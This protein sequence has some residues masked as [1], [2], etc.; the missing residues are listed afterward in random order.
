MNDNPNPLPPDPIYQ[1]LQ[2]LFRNALQQSGLRKIE[3]I[4]KS[5][6]TAETPAKMLDALDRL[7]NGR[8]ARWI[9]IERLCKGLDL[10]VE[11]VWSV[12]LADEAVWYAWASEPRMPQRLFESTH[13]WFSKTHDVPPEMS[14]DAALAWAKSIAMTSDCRW[15]S[16][17]AMR[18]LKIS[19]LPDGTEII[20]KTCPGVNIAAS[21]THNLPPER[22]WPG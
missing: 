7:L 5:G 12:V 16:V 13:R 2:A 17:P 4:R 14:R 11:D 21:R 22:F 1:Q 9:Y 10:Q 18:G 19:Y 15:V 6:T 3:I 8:Q 20:E